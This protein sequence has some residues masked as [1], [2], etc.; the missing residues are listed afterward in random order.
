MFGNS[1]SIDLVY[2]TFWNICNLFVNKIKPSTSPKQKIKVV[3]CFV[4]FYYSEFFA[5]HLLHFRLI[6]STIPFGSNNARWERMFLHGDLFILCF[7]LRAR[8]KHKN[9]SFLNKF[10]AKKINTNAVSSFLLLHSVNQYSNKKK[11]TEL[12]LWHCDV[13]ERYSFCDSHFRH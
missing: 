6:H 1:D 11:N 8:S 13:C 2:S 5:P 3:A 9:N 10:N 4:L 7:F 12:L